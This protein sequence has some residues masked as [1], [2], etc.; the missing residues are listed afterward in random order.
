MITS[1]TKNRP[2]QSVP[3]W[4]RLFLAMLPTIVAQ[5]RVAFRHLDPEAKGEAI[6]EVVANAFVAFARL[7]QL[8]KVDLAYPTALARYAVAQA[9]D[10]RKVGGHL[11]IEDVSSV[12][13][14]RRK[15]ITV[16]RL[17]Q[18]DTEEGCWKE[19]VI[20]DKHST[21]AEV[22]ATRMDFSAWLKTIAPHAADR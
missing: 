10:G 6:Q 18:F 16:D 5:A 2:R 14:Q 19:L 11:N 8:G 1:V 4:H 9:N 17:D 12:Y 13:C 3:A 20:E 21:P 7:V 15:R 22:A